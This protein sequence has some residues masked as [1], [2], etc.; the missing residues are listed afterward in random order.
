MLIA[1]L[2]IELLILFFISR[3]LTEHVYLLAL[4][5]SRS[6]PVA[7]SFVTLLLF[8]GTVIHELAHLFTAEVLGVH[9]GKLTLAPEAIRGDLSA[10]AGEVQAG[11]VAIARTDPFRKAMIGIAPLVV[12]LVAYSMLSYWLPQ[13]LAGLQMVPVDQWLTTTS[14]YLVVGTFYLLF[15]ISNSLF[16]SSLDLEGTPATFITIGV[17]LVAAYIAGIRISLNG[18]ALAITNRI[19]TSLTQSTMLVLALNGA[20]L[21]TIWI[22]LGLSGK[23]LKRK[24]I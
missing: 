22:L 4:I 5:L 19:L 13:F 23:V 12:G 14:F 9:T 18:Q 1:L 11:S 16:P 17:L 21:L 8:P 15:A 2:L 7:I 3:R 24:V 20:L 6:R 10:Q